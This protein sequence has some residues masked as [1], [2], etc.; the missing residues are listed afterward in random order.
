MSLP[1]TDGPEALE[2]AEVLCRDLSAL[3]L[4]APNGAL[5]LTASIGLTLVRHDDKDLDMALARADH[6]LY[7]A[8]R[9]GRNRVYFDPAEDV[10]P[11][12][13]VAT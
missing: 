6:A 7:E 4:P 13:R 9:T 12:V 10:G 1:D 11:A 5:R 8:K 3:R 2:I